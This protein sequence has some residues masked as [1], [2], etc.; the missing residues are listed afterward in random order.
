MAANE[1][2]ALCFGVSNTSGPS[3]DN[4]LA[5]EGV[6]E[7]RL[8]EAYVRETIDPK[9]R[10]EQEGVNELEGMTALE[11]LPLVHDAA[12]QSQLIR[13]LEASESEDHKKHQQRAEEWDQA[14]LR[15]IENPVLSQSFDFVLDHMEQMQQIDQVERSQEVRQQ[16]RYNYDQEQLEQ[17]EHGDLIEG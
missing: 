15:D 3:I 4:T 17:L 12:E 5:E 2:G 6:I 8:L 7:E 14:Q 10:W 9:Q 16:M 13:A 11:Q 1:I